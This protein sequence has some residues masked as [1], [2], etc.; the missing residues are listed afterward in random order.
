MKKQVSRSTAAARPRASRLSSRRSLPPTSAEGF[1]VVGL[2]ASAGGLDAFRRLLA[3]LPADTG[4]AFIF[5]Q[6]LDP[7]HAS[8][9]VD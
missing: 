7:T 1:T 2:G 9:M 6:H 4:M 5:I 8:M 3:A